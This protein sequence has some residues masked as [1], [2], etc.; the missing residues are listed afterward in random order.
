MKARFFVTVLL[1]L[2][3]GACAA[4]SKTSAE[5][6][7]APE[8]PADGPPGP[9]LPTAAEKADCAKRGGEM[10]QVGLQA[11]YACAIPYRDANKACANDADCEGT[12]WIFGHPAGP[13]PKARGFCQPTNLPYGCDSTLDKGVVTPQMCPE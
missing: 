5:A 11:F 9:P 3:L 2:T 12:C 8:A 4:P 1:A 10:K 7:P 13:D 6:P